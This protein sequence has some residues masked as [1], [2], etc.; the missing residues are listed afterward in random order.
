ME[1][2]Y[3]LEEISDRLAIYDLYTRYVHY[4]DAFDH[5]EL[6]RIFGFDTVMDWTDGGYRSMIWK[7]AKADGLMTG[8]SSER[9]AVWFGSACPV[10]GALEDQT[11]EVEKCISVLSRRCEEMFE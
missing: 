5:D 8:V 6:D 1:S 7:E 11:S 3:S 10:A 4:V 2:L 9:F